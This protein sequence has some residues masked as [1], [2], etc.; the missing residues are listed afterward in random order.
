MF[1]LQV[2]SIFPKWLVTR[3]GY[4]YVELLALVGYSFY[5]LVQISQLACGGICASVAKPKPS[6]IIPSRT[7]LHVRANC[8]DTTQQR[9]TY[10]LIRNKYKPNQ[11]G[12]SE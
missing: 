8:K 5:C 3:L 11:P 12:F 1:F 9:T 7:I 6:T 2:I 4:R 10:V